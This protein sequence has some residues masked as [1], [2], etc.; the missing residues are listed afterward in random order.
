MMD[1]WSRWGGSGGTGRRV[2]ILLKNICNS[3]YVQSDP[4]GMFPVASLSCFGNG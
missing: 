2:R 4:W 3:M 1:A